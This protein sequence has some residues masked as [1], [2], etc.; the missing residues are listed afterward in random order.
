MP[1]GADVTIARVSSN[2]RIA[3]AGSPPPRRTGRRGFL[4]TAFGA[5]TL[6]VCLELLSQPPGVAAQAE[7]D[8]ATERDDGPPAEGATPAQTTAGVLVPRDA[9]RIFTGNPA[10]VGNAYEYNVI[11]RVNLDPSQVLE[12]R[13]S[14]D[15]SALE[16]GKSG[17]LFVQPAGAANRASLWGLA[18]HP[19][20]GWEAY[21]RYPNGP[22]WVYDVKQ[23]GTRSL[24]V[25]AL[26]RIA[27]GYGGS[28]IGDK[29]AITGVLTSVDLFGLGTVDIGIGVGG[30]DSRIGLN[31]LEYAI[32]DAAAK[33]ETLT[34][35]A[36]PELGPV[37]SSPSNIEIPIIP[38]IPQGRS[39]IED[40]RHHLQSSIDRTG[41]L[42]AV[43][44]FEARTDYTFSVDAN[45]L[46]SAFGNLAVVIGSGRGGLTFLNVRT[47]TGD[48]SIQQLYKEAGR[49][50]IF[51][52]AKNVPW[53]NRGS[54]TNRIAFRAEGASV[55]VGIVNGQEAVR[56]TFSNPNT[57]KG[58]VGYLVWVGTPSNGKGT[59]AVYYNNSLT[60]N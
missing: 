42:Y 52:E 27:N 16:P 59:H 34:L 47:Y 5:A 26:S 57:L 20:R 30:N 39:W 1:T 7:L 6:A 43:T 9:P 55:A 60:T 46:D 2:L 28:K 50:Q 11:D 3:G 56:Y 12:L 37:I 23:L 4:H 35:A 21:T 31:Y 18:L 13:A 38:E 24:A 40:G 22:Q 25:E 33:P 53:V 32:L 49:T 17:A 29:V 15:M 41:V 58:G 51:A 10:T 14:L 8:G 48:V 36:A 19:T 45:V 44:P 54:A